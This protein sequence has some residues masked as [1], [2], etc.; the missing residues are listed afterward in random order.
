MARACLVGLAPVP[1][2][3]GGTKLAD[4]FRFARDPGI[5]VEWTT[6]HSRPPASRGLVL[7][8]WVA[9]ILPTTCWVTDCL[10][11]QVNSKE[12]LSFQRI[13]FPITQVC[14]SLVCA[15]AKLE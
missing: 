12:V 7:M 11:C 5:I 8:C 6:T 1:A 4:Y 3:T 9:S 2:S 15:L 14:P 10:Q 13:A